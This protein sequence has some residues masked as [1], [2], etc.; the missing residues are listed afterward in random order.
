MS[1]FVTISKLNALPMRL[2]QYYLNKDAFDKKTDTYG[3]YEVSDLNYLYGDVPTGPY[4]PKAAAMGGDARWHLLD[5]YSPTP[6][7]VENPEKLPVIVEIHGGGYLTNNKECNRPHGMYFASKGYKVVNINYTLQPEAEF[8]QEL[9]EIN[10]AFNWIGDN[11][12]KYGFDL[13][14]VFLTGDSSGAH[15]SLLYTAVQTRPDLQE[16]FKVTA[17]E[18]KIKGTALTCPVGSFL[19]PDIVSTA[20][21]NLAGR[22]YDTKGKMNISYQGFADETYPEVCIITTDTD[23]PIHTNSEAVHKWLDFKGVR[24]EYKSFE[25]QGNKLG[26]VFNVLHPDWPESIEANQMILD[27]FEKRKTT[28]EAPAE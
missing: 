28:P 21:R 16:Y 24:H 9:R 4:D 26:H 13:D 6:L 20:F 2:G 14:N 23:V 1:L 11:A 5:V 10:A 25:S 18:V 15:L 22:L 12:D 17:P 8:D 19:D 7:D 3:T 27:F